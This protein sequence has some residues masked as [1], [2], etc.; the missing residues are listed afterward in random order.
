[1]TTA[2]DLCTRALKKLGVVSA[3]HDAEPEDI[4][5][6]LAELNGMLAEWRVDRLMV[7]RL[8]D[9]TK[10][11]DGSATY[12]VGPTGDIVLGQRPNRIEGCYFTQTAGS[13]VV[14]YDGTV[15]DSLEDYAKI[16]LKALATVPTHV[17]YDPVHSAGNGN[18]V[19]YPWPVPDSSWTIH[20]LVRVILQVI[21]TL[22]D[23]ITLPP[24]YENAIV[25]NLA[26]RLS[27]NYGDMTLS[28]TTRGIAAA[29]KRLIATSNLRMPQLQMPYPLR[30]RGRG[31][32]NVYSGR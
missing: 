7:Y 1:M 2:R 25:Y 15:I 3:S 28:P 19:I 10:V 32:F 30:S 16:T 12:T 9:A 11:A 17:F 23:T 24:E 4:N 5:D 14:S 20:L 18:G 21:S 26:V 22:N 31:R 6:A 27:T 13:Q 29:T 8:V